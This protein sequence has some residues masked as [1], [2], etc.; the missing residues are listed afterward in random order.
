MQR[1]CYWFSW[2]AFLTVSASAFAWGAAGHE[3]VGAIA[4]SLIAGTNAEKQVRKILGSNLKTASVWADCAKG[5]SHSNGTFRYTATGQY[6]ECA[7]FEKSAASKAL[8]VAFV[9]RN[10]DGCNPAPGQDPCH[11]QYHYT[12]VAVVHHAY[13]TGLEG[14]SDHDLVAAITAAIAVLQGESAP[15]PFDLAN[16]KEALRVLAHYVGDVHQPLH[17]ASSYLDADGTPVDPDAG[18]FDPG[19]ET[20]GGNSIMDGSRNLHSEWDGISTTLTPDRL[21]PAGLASARAVAQSAGPLSGWSTAWA[22]DTIVV[23]KGAF[24]GLTFSAKRQDHKWAVT[25]PPG[26]SKSRTA[27]QREQLIKAGARLAQILNAIWP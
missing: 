21:L 20:R 10:W 15:A 25:L 19:T 16:K 24:E 22:T 1:I 2:L 18:G 5:V 17:V 6:A 9:K 12:D 11:K 4:D 23:G 3:T 14:T 27:L 8:M 13:A 7:I 26:Y